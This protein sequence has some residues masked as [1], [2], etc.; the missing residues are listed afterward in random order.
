MNSIRIDPNLFEQIEE[1]KKFFA[2]W[3]SDKKQ[4][5][6][7]ILL[8]MVKKYPDNP[9]VLSLAAEFVN[10]AGDVQLSDEYIQKAIELDPEDGYAY[11]VKAIMMAERGMLHAAFDLI[12]E[13]LEKPIKGF[14]V[15]EKAAMTYKKYGLLD[16]AE[17]AYLRGFDVLPENEGF[18]HGYA[19]MYKDAHMFDKYFEVLQSAVKKRPGDSHL[20]SELGITAGNLG[21]SE[22]ALLAIERTH[23]LIQDDAE[24]FRKLGLLYQA[25]EQYEKAEEYFR[26]LVQKEDNDSR[27][28][29]YLALLLKLK[30][31]EKGAKDA[32]DRAVKVDKSHKDVIKHLSERPAMKSK[33][34]VFAKNADSKFKVFYDGYKAHVDL[35]ELIPKLDEIKVLVGIDWLTNYSLRF[36]EP[37]DVDGMFVFFSGFLVAR[38]ELSKALGVMYRAIEKT[39]NDPNLWLNLANTLFKKGKL[40]GAHVAFKRTLSFAPD[41]P[42][43]KRALGLISVNLKLFD[44]AI[45]YL[46]DAHSANLGNFDTA[47]GLA[48]SYLNTEN[49]EKSREYCMKALDINTSDANVY[50]FLVMAEQ[51]LGNSAASDEA[52]KKCQKLDKDIARQY[53]EARAPLR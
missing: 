21:K 6:I 10:E 16:F 11:V 9:G 30:G 49:Y 51:G 37:S 8:E 17:K 19:K 29:A 2:L 20:W 18:W 38:Q 12:I 33:E 23:E 44:E 47:R 39:P 4:E 36:V 34:L 35:K 1:T 41:N 7:Q 45:T 26:K 50:G 5:A 40:H 53:E 28:W 31:D 3:E 14:M 43:I 24:G 27:N 32:F 13:A 52:L 25:V 48:Y 42:E 15:I 46:E 22:D